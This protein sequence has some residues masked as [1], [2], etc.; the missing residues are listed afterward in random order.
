MLE[1]FG[2]T[3]DVTGKRKLASLKKEMDASI[4]IG[5]AKTIRTQAAELAAEDTQSPLGYT[6]KQE[7]YDSLIRSNNID[8][9]DTKVLIKNAFA[10]D[11]IE[12]AFAAAGLSKDKYK[13][14]AKNYEKESTDEMSFALNVKKYAGKLE[15][16]QGEALMESLQKAGVGSAFLNPVK[17]ISQQTIFSRLEN[18]MGSDHI[19]VRIINPKDIK[20]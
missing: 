12:D 14:F 15:G 19:K 16:S 2:K 17:H 7:Y 10:D 9:K 5:A 20:P 11:V 18:A 1:M 13:E 4:A 6:A 3:D 8:G